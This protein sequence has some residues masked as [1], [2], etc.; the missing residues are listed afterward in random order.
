MGRLLRELEFRP[1][2]LEAGQLQP[3]PTMA[4]N[5]NV[6]FLLIG[7]LL[8]GVGV[9]GYELYQEKHPKQPDGVQINLGP[10]GVRIQGSK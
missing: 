7:A 1:G 5:R 9:L 4:I 10:G 6:L 3:G 2:I 8:V